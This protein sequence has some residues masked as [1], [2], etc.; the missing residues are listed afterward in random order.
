MRAVMPK[1]VGFM[2]AK[3]LAQDCKLWIF[4]FVGQMKH[5]FGKEG[6]TALGAWAGQRGASGWPLFKTRPKQH[7]QME[8]QPRPYM[9]IRAC[10]L[11][12]AHCLGFTSADRMWM[13]DQL[14]A[15]AQSILSPN[16]CLVDL[17]VCVCMSQ[18]CGVE[19]V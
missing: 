2:S 1:Y 12:F 5:L 16:C 7:M 4:S 10:S 14:N 3:R 18:L 13:Q 9:C 19:I 15:G 8:I 11:W 6:Y 17:S